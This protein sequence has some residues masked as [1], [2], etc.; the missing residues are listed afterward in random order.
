MD[1][2][3]TDRIAQDYRENGF[4]SPITVMSPADAADLRRRLEAVELKYDPGLVKDVLVSNTQF[5]LP[6][7]YDLIHHPQ[8]VAAARAVLGPDVMCWRTG[9]FIKEPGDEKYISWH[10][11]LH[12]WGLEGGEEVTAWIAFSPSTPKSG[13]MRV[14][15]GTHRIE[16]AQHSDTW[17]ENNLLSRGQRIEEVDE[18][19][20]VDLVLQPGQMSLHHGKTFHGSRPNMSDDRRI[21]YTIRYITPTMRQT[22]AEKDWAR[23]VSGQDPFGHF[24]TFERPSGDLEPDDMAFRQTTIDI[25]AKAFFE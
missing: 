23:L 11:D 3:D 12:Y 14:I 10:Q 22:R 7:A 18:S 17:D 5:V 13:C 4:V 9:F 19:K 8:I 15:P 6:L 1:K 21:G 16:H 25:Q 2:V 20:A 24:E